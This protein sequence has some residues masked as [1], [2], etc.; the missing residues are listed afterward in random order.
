MLFKIISF[1]RAHVL[2]LVADRPDSRP[3]PQNVFVNGWIVFLRVDFLPDTE[4]QFFFSEHIEFLGDVA[5]MLVMLLATVDCINAES[6]H[7]FAVLALRHA[8]FLA[9]IAARL[10]LA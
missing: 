7:G 8:R 3:Q 5:K 4:Q 1:Y 2:I 6:A 10:A 9:L